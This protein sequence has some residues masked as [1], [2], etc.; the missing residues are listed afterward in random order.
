M[1]QD[2]CL[3]CEVSDILGLYTFRIHIRRFIQGLFAN[4]NFDPV[5]ESFALR[6]AILRNFVVKFQEK[7]V[8][9]RD[10]VCIEFCQ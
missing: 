6:S 1:F 5:I 10:T 8:M 2:L 3:Y 7:T 9:S 4:V